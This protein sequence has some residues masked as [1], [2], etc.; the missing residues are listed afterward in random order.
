MTE[1][2]HRLHAYRP[3]I[4]DVRLK[5]QVEA[6]RF[7]EGQLK[8]VVQPLVSLRKAPRFDARQLTEVLLGERLRVFAS[9]EGWAFVQLEGDGYVGYVP[10]DALSEP[11]NPP[12]HRVAVP[13]TFIYPEPSIK[14]QPAEL[15]PLNATVAVVGDDGKFARLANGRFIFSRHLSPIDACESDFVTVAEKFRHAPYYWGG[16]SVR[17]LDCSG[18]VQVS[19]EACGMKSPRDS[20]MQEQSLGTD[21]RINDLDGL[22]RGDLVFWDGHVGIMTDAAALLHANGYHM[23]VEAE[24]LRDAIERIA[25]SYGAVTSIKRL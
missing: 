21:L 6:G 22:R 12:S 8:E 5:G 4:A 3:D 20:D 13:S 11:A 24:P 23:M 15:V 9:E 16:K 14:S 25:Q 18:L 2:D 19:L 10:A 17:G 7:V 1:L